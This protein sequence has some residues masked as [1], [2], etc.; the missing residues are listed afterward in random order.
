MTIR[1]A[2]DPSKLLGFDLQ[3]DPLNELVI[4]GGCTGEAATAA[5]TAKAAGNVKL[6]GVSKAV[7]GVKPTGSAK[8]VGD[9][10]FGAATASGR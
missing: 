8:P 4:P 6:D 9:V 3:G 1:T 5:G 7:G 10:K 2:F